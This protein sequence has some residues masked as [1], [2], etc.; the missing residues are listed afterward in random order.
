MSFYLNLN[1]SDSHDV[2]PHNYG[3]DFQVELADPLFFNEQ[4]PWE[5]AL[6]EMSY[7]AQGFPNIQQEYTEIQVEALNRDNVYD[8]LNKDYSIRATFRVRPKYY[9]DSDS[10]AI[11]KHLRVP[12]FTLPKK[13]YTWEGFKAAWSDLGEV[14]DKAY[15]SYG[16]SFTDTELVCTCNTKWNSGKFEFSPD[17]IEFLSL[18]KSFIETPNHAADHHRNSKV[19]IAYKKPELDHSP[20]IFPLDIMKDHNWIEIG[21]RSV[22]LWIFEMPNTN[23]TLKQMAKNFTSLMS[24]GKIEKKVKFYFQYKDNGDDYYWEIRAET[25][26]AIR[27]TLHFS[28][29]FLN[30]LGSAISNDVTGKWNLYETLRAESPVT[31]RSGNLKKIKKPEKLLYYSRIPFNFYPSSVA[32]CEALTSTI[33]EL[34]SIWTDAR[35]S[36]KEQALFS[37]EKVGGDNVVGNA[38]TGICH[39]KPHPFFNVTLHPNMLKLLHLQNTIKEEKGTSIVLLPSATRDF[40]YVYTS[41]ISS[42]TFSGATNIFRVINNVLAQPNEKVLISFSHFYYHPIVH[43]HIPNIQIRITDNHTDI[44]LP[45]QKNVSCL[46]HFRRCSNPF[47]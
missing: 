12:K 2:H 25:F 35:F 26:Q 1:S 37:M 45:F 11:K 3:G 41:I 22:G 27:L 47:T 23:Y 33:M 7:D 34:A 42:H 46:L 9:V 24:D 40:F 18:E 30:Q 4:D 15:F 20:I 6:V 36:S 10:D 29:S 21:S 32:F 44:E 13:Y 38:I 5:V 19:G 14:G 43:Q 31:I 16:V 39:F 28:R 8:A 17:L